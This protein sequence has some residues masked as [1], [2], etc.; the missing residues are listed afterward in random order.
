MDGAEGERATETLRQKDWM[1]TILWRTEMYRR[2]NW[3]YAGNLSGERTET[4][5]NISRMVFVFVSFLYVR[6][7]TNSIMKTNQFTSTE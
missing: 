3:C 4:D 5:V 7:L 1:W 6:E 2:S